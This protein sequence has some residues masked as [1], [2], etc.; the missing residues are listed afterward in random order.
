MD[1][2]GRHLERE[3]LGQAI[4]DHEH[5]ASKAEEEAKPGMEGAVFGTTVVTE[6]GDEGPKDATG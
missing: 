3:D 6:V 4:G 1:G 5:A 2:G